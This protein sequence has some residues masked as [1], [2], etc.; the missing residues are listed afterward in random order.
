N[1]EGLITTISTCPSMAERLNALRNAGLLTDQQVQ[2][3]T[4]TENNTAA[5]MD[6][7]EQMFRE[8]YPQLAAD[9]LAPAGTFAQGVETTTATTTTTTQAAEATAATATSTITPVQGV[10]AAMWGLAVQLAA[11]TGIQLPVLQATETLD[12]DIT[13]GL[14]AIDQTQ[15]AELL[16]SL[17]RLRAH[18]ANTHPSDWTPEQDLQFVFVL[19]ALDLYTVAATRVQINGLLANAQITPEALEQA[20]NALR[21]N[22]IISRTQYHFIFSRIVAPYQNLT[23]GWNFAFAMVEHPERLPL[24]ERNPQGTIV[25][26]A[27]QQ[28]ADDDG[29]MLGLL[30]ILNSQPALDNAGANAHYL[31][32]LVSS[33]VVT[34]GEAI[35]LLANFTGVIT[36]DENLQAE[37]IHSLPVWW[38]PALVYA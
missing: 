14:S 31:A 22:G 13:S 32:G 17:D 2:A 34:A 28:D 9:T 23:S 8:R 26:T 15:H 1:V 18:F 27:E 37:I 35:R 21:D 4:A 3:I 16:G 7:L 11:D 10:A 5:E 19:N 24:I 12:V 33:G 38:E 36:F 30:N 6:L 20:L 25:L 29:L